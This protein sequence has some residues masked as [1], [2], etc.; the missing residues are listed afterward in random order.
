VSSASSTP[1]T[2]AEPPGAR[3]GRRTRWPALLLALPLASCD[4]SGRCGAGELCVFEENGMRGGM[5]VFT[6]DDGSYV[7][8][9]WPPTGRADNA[10]SSVANGTDRWAVLYVDPDHGGHALCVGPGAF[11]DDL[12]RYEYDAFGHTFGDAISSHELLPVRPRPSTRGGPCGHTVT[13]DSVVGGGGWDRPPSPPPPPPP[14][15]A[16]AEPVRLGPA[17]RLSCG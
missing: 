3:R 11:V 4:P 16:P 10:V 13:G 17:D 8:D 2:T 9:G 6:G 12:E 15:P 5:V 14:A 7:D 1:T